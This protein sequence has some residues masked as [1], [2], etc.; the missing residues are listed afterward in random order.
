MIHYNHIKILSKK[1]YDISSQGVRSG[2][3]FYPRSLV[4]KPHFALR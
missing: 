2:K 3:L 4:E 1:T